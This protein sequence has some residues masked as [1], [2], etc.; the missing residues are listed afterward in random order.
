MYQFVS[1]TFGTTKGNDSYF[2]NIYINRKDCICYSL[3]IYG[4]VRINKHFLVSKTLI[5]AHNN[6]TTPLS[7]FEVKIEPYHCHLWQPAKARCAKMFLLL[8]Q[9]C[10]FSP[11]SSQSLKSLPCFKWFSGISQTTTLI[12]II[13]KELDIDFN[14]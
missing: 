4:L 14:P 7:K 12:H 13:W 5:F 11:T 10:Q 3:F 8:K 2:K 6:T 1:Q 9:F